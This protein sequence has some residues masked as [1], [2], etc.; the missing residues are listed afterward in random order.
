MA[1]LDGPRL[2][3]ERMDLIPATFLAAG[4]PATPMPPAT[5]PFP[6]LLWLG[7]LSSHEAPHGVDKMEDVIE[8]SAEPTLLERWEN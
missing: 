7:Q 5:R 4:Y 2:A 6:E 1:V 8:R 3:C